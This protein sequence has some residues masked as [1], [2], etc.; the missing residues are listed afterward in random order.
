[1][2]AFVKEVMAE[3]TEDQP[4]YN[5]CR[6]LYVIWKKVMWRIMPMEIPHQYPIVPIRDIENVL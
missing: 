6:L 4:H 2:E 3:I 5:T 1:M